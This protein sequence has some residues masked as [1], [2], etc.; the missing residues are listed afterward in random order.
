MTTYADASQSI[1]ESTPELTD[2]ILSFTEKKVLTELIQKF[3]HVFTNKPERTNKLQHHIDILPNTKP[4]N[5]PPYRYVP[6]HL[7]LIEDNLAEMLA[8]GIITPSKSPWTS[9]VVLALKKKMARSDSMSII[10]NLMKLL[11]VMLTP[12]LVST[13]HSTHFNM[14]RTYQHQISTPVTDK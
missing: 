7:K 14:L 2:S 13:I 9:P 4:R 3:P 10:G 1:S 8:Q 12:Y 11:F 6:A 5:T